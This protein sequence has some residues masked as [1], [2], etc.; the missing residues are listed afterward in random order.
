MTN[1][2]QHFL[3]N[4]KRFTRKKTIKICHILKTKLLNK[5]INE[6]F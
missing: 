6:K 5:P 3:R 2:V 4:G 1:Y